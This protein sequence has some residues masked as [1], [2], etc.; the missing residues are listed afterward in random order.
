MGTGR[1]RFHWAM[2]IDEKGG[3]DTG[4]G[5]KGGGGG[6]GGGAL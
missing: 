2:Y 3:I 5:K 4:E 1:C 6:G